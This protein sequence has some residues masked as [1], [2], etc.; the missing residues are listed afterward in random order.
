M[1]LDRVT[2]IR[3]EVTLSRRNLLALLTKLDGYP[4]SSACSIAT[5]AGE[6]PVL[7]VRAEPDQA[8]YQHRPEPGRMHRDTEARLSRWQV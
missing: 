5:S 2:S 7:V 3:V 6:G 1:R 8:H 4:P